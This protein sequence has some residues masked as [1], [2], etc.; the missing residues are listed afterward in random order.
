MNNQYPN[1]E[2]V[3]AS[4]NDLPPVIA[5][6][7]MQQFFRGEFDPANTPA[8]SA[9]LLME[10]LSQLSC[11]FLFLRF[12]DTVGNYDPQLMLGESALW[13]QLDLAYQQALDSLQLHHRGLLCCIDGFKAILLFLDDELAALPLERQYKALE[14]DLSAQQKLLSD[15]LGRTIQIICSKIEHGLDNLASAFLGALFSIDYIP[16]IYPGKDV[17]SFYTT[18]EQV[19]D[20]SMLAPKPEWEKLYFNAIFDYNFNEAESL[21]FSLI[22]REL[23]S[24]NSALS[25][26]NRLHNR[27]SC[28]LSILGFPVN[29]SLSDCVRIHQIADKIVSSKTIL[30]M[31]T[32]IKEFFSGLSAYYQAAPVPTE[33][34]LEMIMDYIANNYQ[35]PELSANRLSELFHISLGHLSRAFKQKT[36]IK[37]ID[38]I[39]LTRVRQARTLILETDSNLHDI[40]LAVGYAGEWSLNRAFKRYESVTPGSL[41][42]RSG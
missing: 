17:I 23:S 9:D 40:A 12:R 16:Q 32:Y 31:N 39:H 4:E 21:L 36:G 14:A 35:N 33:Q 22:A 7:L 5:R 38:Y 1:G 26:R 30:K 28:T 29:D 34:K 20:T 8:Q 25:I 11:V 3:L 15:E 6:L 13:E 42:A 2:L 41:R 19:P 27:L 37:L 18:M 24:P 10:R